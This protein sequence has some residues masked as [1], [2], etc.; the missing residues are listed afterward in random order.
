MAMGIN[1]QQFENLRKNALCSVNKPTQ[2]FKPRIAIAAY[3]SA[4]SIGATC[5][6]FEDSKSESVFRSSQET[7]LP[8]ESHFLV[9]AFIRDYS[10]SLQSIPYQYHRPTLP[11]KVQHA[12]PNMAHSTHNSLHSSYAILLRVGL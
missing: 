1:H 10:R 8:L 7:T 3:C 9:S 12:S 11:G 5:S 4:S 6:N 2:F